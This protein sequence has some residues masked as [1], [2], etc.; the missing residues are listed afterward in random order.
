MVLA[1]LAFGWFWWQTHLASRRAIQVELLT[2]GGH[3]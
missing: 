3:P 2:D 1:L